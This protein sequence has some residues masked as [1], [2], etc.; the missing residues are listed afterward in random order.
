MRLYGGTARGLF[1]ILTVIAFQ[2]ALSQDAFAQG[3][4]GGNLSSDFSIVQ[5]QQA[6]TH[7]WNL[8][9][10]LKGFAV[11]ILLIMVVVAA[12]MATFQR[13]GMAVMVAVGGV[14]LFGGYYVVLL[15]YQGLN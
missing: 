3:L 12:V 1:A 5:S 2:F 4:T 8:H 11:V 14:I 6:E 15:L 9:L 10:R 7:F 13:T